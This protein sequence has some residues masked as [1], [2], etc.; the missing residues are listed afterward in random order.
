MESQ[1]IGVSCG[2]LCNF[3]REK[4]FSGAIGLDVTRTVVAESALEVARDAALQS[5]KIKEPSFWR[6]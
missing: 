6:T 5:T 4:Y 3:L 2:F 1:P